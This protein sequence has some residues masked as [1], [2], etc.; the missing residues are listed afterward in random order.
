MKVPMSE[1]WWPISTFSFWYYF[2]CFQPR[3]GR[4][5]RISSL[6][7]KNFLINNSVPVK[8]NILHQTLM[9]WV[10]HDKAFQETITFT[11]KGKLI[12]YLDLESTL[13]TFKNG[14][15]Y[16]ATIKSFKE[17]ALVSEGKFC[18]L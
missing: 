9:S 13:E 3:I 17:N 5:I 6:G 2:E 10:Q 18:P 15:P 7:L 16:L 4:K 12:S 1:I 8:F 11:D 14:S